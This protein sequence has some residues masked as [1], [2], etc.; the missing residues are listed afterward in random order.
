[1]MKAV[2]KK[3]KNLN[4]NLKQ[5]EQYQID[6]FST[7]NDVFRHFKNSTKFF[8]CLKKAKTSRNSKKN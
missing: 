4:V 3:K 1:M 2:K 5:Y 8:I 7:K 6:V